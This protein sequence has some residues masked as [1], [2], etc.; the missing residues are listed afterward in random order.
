MLGRML[1]L[2]LQMERN[3]QEDQHQQ[4]D[5]ALQKFTTFQ[6]GDGVTE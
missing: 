4:R 3:K 6:K 2:N 1:N 5:L